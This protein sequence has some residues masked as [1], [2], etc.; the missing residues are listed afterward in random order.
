MQHRFLVDMET[1]A[2]AAEVNVA[3]AAQHGL[4]LGA[5][6]GLQKGGSH[7]DH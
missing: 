7:S 5:H 6:P 3:Q 4:F 2:E 1:E